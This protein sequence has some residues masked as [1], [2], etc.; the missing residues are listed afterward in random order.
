MPPALMHSDDRMLQRFDIGKPS[1]PLLD[2]ITNQKVPTKGKRA[3]VPGCGRG[4]DVVAFALAEVSATGHL[5]A[6]WN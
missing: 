2:I 3:L 6:V 5:L 1:A 4:Y